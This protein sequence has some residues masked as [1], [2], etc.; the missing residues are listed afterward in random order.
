MRTFLAVCGMLAFSVPAW[1][2]DKQ[3]AG[4]IVDS[5]TFGVYAGGRRVATETFSI[6]QGPDGSVVTSQFKSAQ[7][8]QTAE[9][10]S[11]LQ[12]TPSV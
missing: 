4:G 7:G 10:A 12:L 11:E 6:R 2:K 5:G 8:E 3:P 1:P 9:Q